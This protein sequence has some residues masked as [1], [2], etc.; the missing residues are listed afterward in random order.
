M[1]NYGQFDSIRA[2]H[3]LLVDGNAT[4]T[5]TLTQTGAVA[6]TG[7]LAVTGAASVASTLEVTDATTLTGATGVT[8]MLSPNGG[9]TTTV[10]VENIGVPTV[11]STAVTFESSGALWT[12]GDG[13]IWVIHG[14]WLNV[15]TNFDSGGSND[16]TLQVGDGGDANGL[17][18][19][20]DAELQAAAVQVTGAVA[21]W[22][23]S[24]A[25]TLG[26]YMA[27]G[28]FIYAPSGADETIDIVTGGTGADAG[29]GT[30]YMMYTRIA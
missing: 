1:T 18:D 10:N 19:M 17:L 15:T 20:V 23:G 5:G 14:L 22:H 29:A 12:I 21:G 8:G 26:A 27:D 6:V 16:N 9:I 7:A 2:Q 11:V 28:M 13:E 3:D 30:L 4:I 25:A 24:M